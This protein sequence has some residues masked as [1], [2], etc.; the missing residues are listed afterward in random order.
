M[1]TFFF[2]RIFANLGLSKFTDLLFDCADVNEAFEERLGLPV[3]SRTVQSS[4]DQGDSFA[5]VE[6]QQLGWV[7]FDFLLGDFKH[8]LCDLLPLILRR[9]S[10]SVTAIS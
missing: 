9:T 8:R 3:D 10:A 7:S 6:G 2:S 1:D 4:V 5:A